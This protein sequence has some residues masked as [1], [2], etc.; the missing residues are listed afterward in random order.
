MAVGV[1]VMDLV[2]EGSLS[3]FS[4]NCSEMITGRNEQALPFCLDVRTSTHA[5]QSISTKPFGRE[6]T[7]SSP[8]HRMSSKARSFTWGLPVTGIKNPARQ[9]SGNASF[10][11]N[12]WLVNAMS[13]YFLAKPAQLS[14]GFRSAH[15]FP[16]LSSSGAYNWNDALL[17][18]FE[19]TLCVFFW[20]FC[21]SFSEEKKSCRTLLKC[22]V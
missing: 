8:E 16:V 12:E 5:I 6:G 10:H 3:T 20:S 4:F 21:I 17:R 15:M 7:D 22:D 19:R 18:I 9:Q 14:G 2:Q 11:V 13:T 1:A